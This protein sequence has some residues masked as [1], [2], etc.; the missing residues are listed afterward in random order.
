MRFKCEHHA[1]F[2]ILLPRHPAPDA[3]LVGN[4]SALRQHDKKVRGTFIETCKNLENFIEILD[5]YQDAVYDAQ[6]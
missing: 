6:L 3:R 4:F 2:P 1:A 5:N